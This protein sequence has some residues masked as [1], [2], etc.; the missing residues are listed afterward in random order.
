MST[1]PTNL[2]VT[3]ETNIKC[4]Y[5]AEVS[6]SDAPFSAEINEDSPASQTSFVRGK[7]FRNPETRPPKP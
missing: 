5:C 7:H 6:R 3:A 2:T 4:P 1:T